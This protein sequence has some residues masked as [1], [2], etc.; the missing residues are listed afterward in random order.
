MSAYELLPTKPVKMAVS[1]MTMY[2]INT[3]RGIKTTIIASKIET[4][5]YFNLDWILSAT[6]LTP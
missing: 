1:S 3:I 4:E 5:E 2:A 6:G